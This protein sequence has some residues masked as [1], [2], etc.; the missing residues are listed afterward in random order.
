MV[1]IKGTNKSETLKG[2]KKDE[3]IYGLDGD[4]NLFSMEGDDRIYGGAGNDVMNGYIGKDKIFGGA[5][6]D[7]LVIASGADM[8]DGGAGLDA[9]DFYY[10]KDGVN[11][12]LAKGKA[13]FQANY[14][15]GVTTFK[16]VEIVFGSL[17][18]DKLT[19]DPKNNFLIGYDGSDRLNGGGGNDIIGGYDGRD[20]LTGGLGKDTFHFFSAGSGNK[21]VITDFKASEDMFYLWGD[22][23]NKLDGKGPKDTVGF[24]T[25]RPLVEEQFEVNESGQAST[26]KT[27]LIYET[28][29]GI[30]WY[31]ANGSGS[32]ERYIVAE[33]D[34]KPALTF[35]NFV[36]PL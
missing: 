15:T 33:L 25:V 20:R 34:G 30:L 29:T 4:D 27:R 10:D 16:N 18:D 32:G 26:G 13:S 3:E 17:K 6:H 19:G 35:D 12:D 2:T 14:G 5:G 21:D 8:F 7:R 9:I 24:A 22:Y 36:V 31:A 28:D 11:V 1:K 23:F